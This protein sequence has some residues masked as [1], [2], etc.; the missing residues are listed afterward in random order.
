MAE[1]TLKE[2]TI[3]TTGNIP[4]EVVDGPNY[5]SALK[6]LESNAE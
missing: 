2:N 4:K 6:S 5:N 1:I 3:H